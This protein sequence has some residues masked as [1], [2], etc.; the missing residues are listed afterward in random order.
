MKTL[1][2]ASTSSYRRELLA[3]LGVAFSVAAPDCDEDA[4]KAQGHAPRALASLLA[5]EKAKSVAALH[6]D[7]YVLGSDQLVDLD[8][9][10]LGKP[11]SVEGAVAQLLRMQGRSHALITATALVT[12]EGVWHEHVDTHALTLRSLSESEI[13]RY[14]ERDRP[15]DCAGSYKIEQ[16]GIA[17]CARVEGEDFTAITGLPLVHIT[18]LLRTLGFAV[19]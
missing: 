11:G 2:L 9:E 6:P 13:R 5:R 8:G 14:V 16:G 3:R 10:V 12:P 7:V 18:S 15:L 17:L 1:L 19:P 4:Y